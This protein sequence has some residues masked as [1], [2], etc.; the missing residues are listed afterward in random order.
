MNN[1]LDAALDLASRG[2]HVFPLKPRDKSPIVAGGFKAATRDPDYI[3]LWWTKT[4]EANIG[5]A[6][7]A[8]QL[9][10]LDADHGLTSMEE[11]EAWR[12]RNGLPVTY[13]VRS[14]R[15]PEFG[16]QMYFKGPVP[17]SKF[18]LDGVRGEI[19]SA[20]GLVVSPPSIHP[21]SGEQYV[22]LVD[23]PIALT[24]EFIKQLKQAPEGKTD[25]CGIDTESRNSELCSF[26][27]TIRKHTVALD[28]DTCLVL[29]LQRNE[30][31][32]KGP[33]PEEEVKEVVRKQYRLYPDVHPDPV[34]TIGGSTL[35][36]PAALPHRKRP[37]YP[38]EVW[39]GT[40]L[41]EFARLCANDNN[42]PRKLFAES[43]RCALGAVV[44]DRLLCPN[45]DGGL[46][47]S[48]TVIVAPKGK[49]KGTAIRRAV[50]F[51]RQTWSSPSVSITPGLLSGDRDFVWKPKGIG[52]WVAAASSVPGM[53]RLTKDLESTL[54][55]K[56]HLT[57][58]NT[59][60][61]ILSVHEEMKTFLST[62]F[63]EGGVGSGMEGVVCQLWDDIS[64]HGT[65]TGTRDA[66]YGE[67]MFS[68]LC[69]VTEQD[70]FDLLGRG[71]AVGGGLISRLNIIGTE[72]EYENVS[73]LRP[74]DFKP[75][76][77]TFLPRVMRLED[78]HANVLSSDAA[79]TIVGEWFDNL[80]EGSER[81]N[82]HAW[83]SAL[84]LAWLKHE[85]TITAK[86]AED[87]VRLAQYQVD[88]HEYYR[89]KAADN[90]NARI[91]AKLLRALELKGPAFKRELQQRT[92][93]HRDGTEHWSRALDGL[94][95]DGSVGRRE[96]GTYYRA[97]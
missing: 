89:T 47:R 18:D 34:V 22:V 75:L 73:K 57:W 87:A 76:Q 11:F 80:P 29:C 38:I 95:K 71:D 6:C 23:A 70:W 66:V 16:V 15:R 13:T 5:I 10:V 50:Q 17:D 78:A 69:G 62:L 86:A 79:D 68:M 63:I 35:P 65:A 96:D 41:G 64:F 44:G 37:V 74:L 81:M 91:Q 1:F 92:N 19:K 55:N 12:I 60:P 30:R 54:K 31:Y 77:E 42:I 36:E 46:P 58:G 24:P 32:T 40:A 49:G 82:I 7:G 67:M 2:F 25:L 8:S 27:G 52:A 9:C 88:S 84:L 45:A 97:E 61:R 56:P 85:E 83:R 4:P 43:F 28:E 94:L 72:G 59:L 14:G 93:A 20:G 3:R 26:I 51:F 39:D 53:S 90:V 21:D 33:L 48:Y